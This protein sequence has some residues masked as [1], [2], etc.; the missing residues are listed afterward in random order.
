VNDADLKTLI[1]SAVDGELAGHRTAPRWDPSRLTERRLATHP[2]ARWSVPLL[3]ASVAALLAAGTVV[4]IGHGQNG[5]STPVANPATSTPSASP[6]L[7]QSINP[8]QAAA[9]RAYAEAMAGAVEATDAAGVSVEPLSAKDAVQLKNSS[10]FRAD[11]AIMAPVPGKLY[12]FTISYLAGPSSEP[13]TVLTA[14]VRDVASGSCAQPFLARPGHAYRI[15]C[16]VM[17]L[18]GAVGKAELI[19]RSPGGPASMSIDV[20][21]PASPGLSSSPAPH[22]PISGFP[23]ADNV[24]EAMG[25][26][27]VSVGP[28]SAQDARISPGLLNLGGTLPTVLTPGKQYRFTTKYVTSAKDAAVAILSMQATNVTSLSCPQPFLVRPSHIYLVRCTVIARAGVTGTLTMTLQMPQG[29]GG[30]AGGSR[31]LRTS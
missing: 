4:A 9:N 1:N 28:V 31:D 10:S 18:A 23:E 8:D 15:R 29:S 14:T 30:F 12:S 19:A 3:A 5:R 11:A 2:A 25:V 7:S 13:P 6:S 20:T 17:L 16:Q 24:P 22:P 21:D 27:G 26:P